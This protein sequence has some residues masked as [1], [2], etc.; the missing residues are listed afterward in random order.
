M[1]PFVAAIDQ[2]MD[3]FKKSLTGGAGGKGTFSQILSS[4]MSTMDCIMIGFLG[5][6]ITGFL[7]LILYSAKPFIGLITYA[8]VFS[9]LFVIAFGTWIVNGMY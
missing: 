4:I 5:A 8:M 2:I 1:Q 3:S 7:V 6:A 9:M